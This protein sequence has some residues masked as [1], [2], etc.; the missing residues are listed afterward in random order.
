MIAPTGDAD[1]RG[2]LAPWEEN[3]HRLWSLWDMIPI[4][5]HKYLQLG[6]KIREAQHLLDHREGK[7]SLVVDETHGDIKSVLA[8]LRQICKDLNLPI[9]SSLTAEDA[10][11]PMTSRELDVMIRCLV[12][13]LKSQLFAFIP[14]YRAKYFSLTVEWRSAFP[15]AANEVQLAG[16]AYAANLPTA[17]V[18]HSMR[19]LE[20]GL[21]GLARDVGISPPRPIETLQWANIIDQIEA[22]IRKK[23]AAPGATSADPKINFWSSAASQ[24]FV[25]KEAWRN[26]TMHVRTVYGEGEAVKILDA[27]SDFMSRLSEQLTE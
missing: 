22:E 4:E 15:N 11:P 27:V 17:A 2:A 6:G 20:W 1:P 26:Q 3:P 14:T 8:M 9:A 19:A 10:P 18:Y 24:F 21:H 16:N 5:A 23:R 12:A 13:E 25:F 7:S